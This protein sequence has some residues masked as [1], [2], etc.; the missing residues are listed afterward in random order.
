MSTNKRTTQK[1]SLIIILT[2]ACSL[3]GRAYEFAGGTGEPNDPYQIA[4]I[5]DLLAVGSSADLLTKCYVLVNDL[6]LDP[7]LPGGCVFDDALIAGNAH[8]SVT[9][10]WLIPFS[11]VLNGGGHT[12]RNL[13]MLPEQG[14]WI[15]LIGWH[16]GLVKDLHLRDVQVG[17]SMYGVGA[18]AGCCLGGSI[19][20]CSATGQVSGT[21]GAGGIVGHL[22]RGILMDCRTDVYVRGT[23]LV[24]GLFGSSWRGTVSRCE[25][26]AE[27]RG[28]HRVGGLGGDLSQGC[29]VESRAG[30]VVVGRDYV[31]GLVGHVYAWS[32]VILRCAATCEVVA[33]QTAG[34]L[35]GNALL[36][37]G[38]LLADC[39][40]RGSVTGSPAGGLAGAIVGTSVLNSYAACEMIP[41]T[42]SDGTAPVVGGLFGQAS[43][44]LDAP[45]DGC[46][47]DSQLSVVSVGA[48]SD[49]TSC[50]IGLTT[51][52]MQQQATFEQAGW[53]FDSIWAMT[54]GEYPALQWELAAD[55]APGR[56]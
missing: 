11:G 44:S 49:S 56:N 52:Q 34:G 36:S 51:E 28:D 50:G 10:E 6:D 35:V 54:E 48:G 16:S 45:M 19:L 18:I 43:P 20:R 22:S 4:T 24:G 3:T 17:G 30:G 46:F 41:A 55:A 15:G 25:A 21:T 23:T 31:G 40:A 53:D 5:E 2:L 33:E 47:W 27:V 39:Y 29:I 32:Q 12:I 42:T 8:D 13:C 1:S 14:S 9:G 26:Q 37:S 7:N 38:G